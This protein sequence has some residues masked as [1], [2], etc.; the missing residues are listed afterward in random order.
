V[1][2]QILPNLIFLFA[3]LGIIILILRRVPQATGVATWNRD[4]EEG[5]EMRLRGKGMPAATLSTTRKVAQVGMKKAW[6]FILEAKGLS[7]GPKVNYR[8]NKLLKRSEDKKAAITVELNEIYYIDQIKRFPKDW[9]HYNNLGQ[10][11]MANH[12]FKDAAGV[13]EY[14]TKQ[15]PMSDDFWARLGYAKICLG[16]YIGAADSYEKAVELDESHPNRYYNL[17]LAYIELG[18]KGKAEV[19]L[20]SAIKLEPENTKYSDALAEIKT[21]P[22]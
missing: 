14:L 19:A 9:Q 10:Y 6:R 8:I 12:N 16:D 22:L 11:Y 2:F 1:S 7:Q 15:D 3:V 20:E 5:P 21:M 13:Y 18:D 17:A 4:E